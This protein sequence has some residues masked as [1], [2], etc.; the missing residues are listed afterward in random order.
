[1]SPLGAGL[2]QP[3]RR[4][5][6]AACMVMA[7]ALTPPV[8]DAATLAPRF[9]ERVLATHRRLTSWRLH[10]RPQLPYPRALGTPPWAVARELGALTGRRHRVRLVRHLARTA[11]P[12]SS[13]ALY[14]GSRLLPRHVVL[15]VGEGRC[16][17]PSSGRVLPVDGPLGGWRHRWFAITPR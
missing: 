1:M 2:R 3:D 16:Y 7:E 11:G 4:S 5:C 12:P 9:A 10:G 17:E 8:E 14:V 13:G 6:G 15:L